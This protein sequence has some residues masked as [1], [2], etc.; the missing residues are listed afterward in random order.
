MTYT[1]LFVCLTQMDACLSVVQQ[2]KTLCGAFVRPSPRPSPR[3]TG[4]KLITHHSSL[5]LSIQDSKFEIQ[6]QFITHHHSSLITLDPERLKL[7]A[8]PWRNSTHLGRNRF[9]D[10]LARLPG[11]QFCVAQTINP[12][13]LM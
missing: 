11:S 7:P 12:E 3:G 10:R 2:H 6:E 1:I 13:L 8:I 9:A 5:L 4:R